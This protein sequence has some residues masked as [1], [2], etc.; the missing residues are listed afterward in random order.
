MVI[1]F[2]K[3]AELKN[4]FSQALTKLGITDIKFPSDLEQSKELLGN[5]PNAPLVLGWSYNVREENQVLAAAQAKIPS[6]NRPIIVFAPSGDQELA[7]LVTDYNVNDLAVGVLSPAE[8]HQ[9]LLSFLKKI[10]HREKP[11]ADLVD[12]LTYKQ[13]GD[14]AKADVALKRALEKDPNN[15]EINVDYCDNLIAREKWRE[16][17]I[18]IQTISDANP[19]HLRAKNVL[20]RCLMKDGQIKEAL[21]LWE[22]GKL[23]NPHN[24]DRLVALGEA[25]LEMYRIREARENFDEANRLDRGNKGAMAGKSQTMLIQGNYDEAIKTLADFSKYEKAT[26]FNS[27]AILQARQ[28]HLDKALTLYDVAIKQCAGNDRII[29]RLHFNK[30]L[31]YYKSD[32]SQPALEEFEKALKL[33]PDFEKVQINVRTM[34]KKLGYKVETKANDSFEDDFEEA[35]DDDDDEPY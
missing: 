32:Q 23:I 25:L 18:K 4:A 15:V 7:A 34:R 28:R 26:V 35:F 2:L 1:V 21:R 27:A 19:D 3:K 31:A 17:H 10:V 6:L 16:A 8:I 12:A 24:I 14:F 30:G 5:F 13:A 29:A 33:Y 22:Q 9:H 20:A 11:S